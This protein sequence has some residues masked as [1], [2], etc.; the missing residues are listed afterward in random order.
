MPPPTMRVWPVIQLAS[1][2]RRNAAAPATSSEVPSRLSGYVRATS[3]SWAP[4]SDAANCVLITAGGDRIDP[5]GGGKLE[6]ELARHLQQARLAR[7]VCCQTLVR[8][9]AS[10]RR[11]VEDHAAVLSH[12]SV[13][14]CA[15]PRH[16]CQKVDCNDLRRGSRVGVQNGPVERIDPALFTSMSMRSNASIVR[17]TASRWWSTSSALPATPIA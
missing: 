8:L 6:R 17:A 5:D 7:S 3:R 11:H 16:R 9:E 13:S 12:P 10:R 2:E 1:S 4:T 14:S 15:A